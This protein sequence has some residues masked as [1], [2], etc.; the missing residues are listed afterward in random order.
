MLYFDALASSGAQSEF[1]V[2]VKEQ[3]RL[4][5][6]FIVGADRSGTTLLQAMLDAHPDLA[7]LPETYWLPGALTLCQ[8][9]AESHADFIRFVEQQERWAL[10]NLTPEALEA[11]VGAVQ[12]FD[13]A[14]AM[15]AIYCLYARNAGKPRWGDKTPHY[16]MHLLTVARLF[17][18]AHFIHVIRDGRDQALSILAVPWGP[19]TLV[20]AAR[21]WHNQL[22]W[23][24]WCARRVPH[25]IEVHYED[26]VS[27]PEQILQHICAYLHLPWHPQ[28]LDYPR[29]SQV[30]TNAAYLTLTHNPRVRERPQ[31]RVAR[32]RSEMKAEDCAGFE[33]LAGD[34]LR[35]LGYPLS[36]PP[37]RLRQ[38]QWF[39]RNALQKTRWRLRSWLSSLES[40]FG[41][42]KC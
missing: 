14:A 11:A 16:L 9:S 7:V 22:S 25:Y 26:L 2:M 32:W 33:A 35:D 42:G 29:H 10:L 19:T 12:P 17:P 21:Q 40:L 27:N 37:S 6:P 3:S 30:A 23:A 8:N 4:P 1:A 34:L 13:L 28:M 20:Q 24:R 38:A 41:R 39:V 5:A 31:R 18:E 15:R 36:A